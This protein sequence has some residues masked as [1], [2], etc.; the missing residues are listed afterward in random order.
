M[1]LL[2]KRDEKPGAFGTRYD[3]F[4]KLELK[5]EELARIRKTKQ[6]KT[7]IVEDAYKSNS[8]KWKL[9]LIPAGV[10]AIILALFTFHTIHPALGLPVLIIALFAFRKLFFNQVT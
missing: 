8:F 9:M 3:L 4:A 5:P 6:E 2:L 10:L 7:V 1:E